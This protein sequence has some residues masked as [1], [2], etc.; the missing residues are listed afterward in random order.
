M[1]QLLNSI[2]NVRASEIEI[3]KATKKSAKLGRVFDQQAKNNSELVALREGC[4]GRAWTHKTS[5]S[6]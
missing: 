3:Q 2:S 4:I 5:S 1:A 6:K